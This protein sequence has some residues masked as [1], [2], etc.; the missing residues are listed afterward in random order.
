[1]KRETFKARKKFH[2]SNARITV[3]R[4]TFAATDTTP[5]RTVITLYGYPIV[6]NEL[7][8]DRGGYSVRIQ[9]GA[10]QFSTPAMALYHHDFASLIGN[11]ANNT[12]RILQA[13]E[14][15]VPVEIDLPDTT[16]GRDVAELVDKGYIGG[17]SFSMANGF[18]SY[19]ESKEGGVNV[20]SCSKFTCDEVTVTPIPA[21]TGTSIGA[22][23]DDD[24]EEEGEDHSKQMPAR[25]AASLKLHELRL[26]MHRR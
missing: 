7:S 6:F 24:D 20:I 4:Q 25:V 19:T 1:M 13:D 2:N 11:T 17:M 10:A 9:P 15:G 3:R 26:G 21:F 22:K 14:T 8:G 18:E 5:A 16:T 23:A 12:L